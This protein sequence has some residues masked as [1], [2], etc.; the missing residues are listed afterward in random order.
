MLAF[1]NIC[2]RTVSDWQ[3]LRECAVSILTNAQEQLMETTASQPLFYISVLKKL[4][5]YIRTYDSEN[6]NTIIMS[7]QMAVTLLYV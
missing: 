4:R 2:G 7:C 1:S 3:I 6:A 5:V